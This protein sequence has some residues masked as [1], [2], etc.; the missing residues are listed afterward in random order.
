MPLTSAYSPLPF[1]PVVELVVTVVLLC[2]SKDKASAA[3]VDATS[4][5]PA[6]ALLILFFVQ[7][8]TRT[9]GSSRRSSGRGCSRPTRCSGG[10][11]RFATAVS[12]GGRTA[13]LKRHPSM[14]ATSQ[15]LRLLP[16]IRRDTLE[17]TT[18]SQA[19]SH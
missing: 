12:S 15:P 1:A 16:C 11:P 13:L 14:T 17:A 19:P 3:L 9:P 7:T 5:L 18:S 6:Y 8:S 10:R 4:A 2:S